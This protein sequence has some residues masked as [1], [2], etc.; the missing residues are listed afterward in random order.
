MADTKITALAAITTVDPAAD[1]LPIV[2][3]SDTSMAASGT[4]KKITSNQI[5]GAGG[6]ATLASATI[7]GDLTVDTS[8]LK[9]DSANN[10]VGI[11]T[12]TPSQTLQVLGTSGSVADFCGS[13]VAGQQT[14]LRVRTA[15]GNANG[16]LIQG[17]FTTDEIF[18]NNFYNASLIFGVNNTEQM[19]LNSTGLGVGGTPTEKLSV[20]G[21]IGLQNGGTQRWHISASSGSDLVF[22]RS[23]VADRFTITSDGN[24]G[25]GVTPSGSGGC[26]QLKSGITFPATQVASSD[27]NTLDDYEEGTWTG[28]LTGGTTN[29]TTPVTATGRYTKIGRQVYVQISFQNVDTTGASGTAIIT[30]LPFTSAA[31]ALGSVASY[32]MLSF[33]G[34]LVSSIGSSEAFISFLASSSGST[35][36]AATHSAGSTRF[37]VAEMT[38]TV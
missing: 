14:L 12:A 16:L 6:T 18:I 5:L 27:A 21:S 20:N 38:Y 26:L 23:S 4:T 19:R 37:L 35:W 13:G 7:T 29:P 2:D 36:N 15:T 10:R 28:T 25:V 34:S 31:G 32:S 30:G 8:T 11:G 24:V 22:T 33:T 3:I 1:V 9:V 17:N